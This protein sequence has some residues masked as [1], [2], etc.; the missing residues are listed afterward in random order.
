MNI[1]IRVELLPVFKFTGKMVKCRNNDSK[2][3][4]IK[5]PKKLNK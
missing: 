5:I 2:F 4:S 3:F 1:S